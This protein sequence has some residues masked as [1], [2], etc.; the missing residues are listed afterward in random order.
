MNPTR[1]ILLHG[2]ATTGAV[3]DDVAALVR[4]SPDA[5][6][7]IAPDRPC[8][9]NLAAEVAW[10]A[11]LAKGALVVGVGSGATLCLGLAASEV[12]MAAGFAHEPAVG[13]LFPELLSPMVT[14]YARGGARAYAKALYGDEWDASML[15]DPEAVARDFS[16]LRTYWPAPAREGQGSVLVTVGELSP[17]I[18]HQAAGTLSSI[19]GYNVVTLPRARHFVQRENPALVAEWIVAMVAGLRAGRSAPTKVA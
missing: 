8:T 7:V 15:G 16:M 1:V 14:A 4:N 12:K 11:P 5:P 6:E 18:R 10:A 3:W 9:G 2:A 19:V 17:P 13:H